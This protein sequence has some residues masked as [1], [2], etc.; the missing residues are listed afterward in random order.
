MF[1]SCNHTN[2]LANL[3]P[4]IG[5]KHRFIRPFQG[6]RQ[7]DNCRRFTISEAQD[8]SVLSNGSLSGFTIFAPDSGAVSLLTLKV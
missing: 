4:D 5:V 8:T 6:Y 7:T 2:R 1:L 3:M